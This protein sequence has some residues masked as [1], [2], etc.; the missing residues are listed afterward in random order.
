[1]ELQLDQ[2]VAYLQAAHIF[3]LTQDGVE[4]DD[5]IAA[6]TRLAVA[7]GVEVI[8][9]SSDKDFMQLI[10]PEVRLLN[11][12]DKTEAFWGAAEVKA[13]T[14]VAPTQI[15]DWLSLTGDSV[16]NIPGVPGV[17]AKTACDLL[18]QFGSVDEL[19]NQ[20]EE[21]RSDRLRANLQSSIEAVRRNQKLVRLNCDVPCNVTWEELL[22]K[23]VDQA[24]L[25]PLYAQWG[26]KTLLR[27]LEQASL[28]ARELF[29]ETAGAY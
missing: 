26:F 20:L 28:P 4:A 5:C 7:E 11:P 15:V 1:L 29:P 24:A 19:Y 21:V 12:N 14:G 13:K 2:I 27:E 22:V 9:A 18:T 17:G 3:S 8:I 10:S 25:R 6:L 16:D 23:Q